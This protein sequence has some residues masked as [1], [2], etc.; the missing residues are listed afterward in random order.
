MDHASMVLGEPELR[1]ALSSIYASMVE[2]SEN[3][4]LFLRGDPSDVRDEDA[5]GN[6]F[7]R[8]A[9]IDSCQW[10]ADLQI[11]CHPD[12]FDAVLGCVRTA[13]RYLKH[14]RSTKSTTSLTGWAFRKSSIIENAYGKRAAVTAVMPE[15]ESCMTMRLDAGACGGVEKGTYEVGS[16]TPMMLTNRIHLTRNDIS[17]VERSPDLKGW[18][19]LKVA[20]NDAGTFEESVEMDRYCEIASVQSKR[21]LHLGAPITIAGTLDDVDD[22]KAT[23]RSLVGKDV[24]TII[25]SA[26][27][28]EYEKLQSARGRPCR[29]LVAQ[30]YQ[31]GD[32]QRGYKKQ[33][34]MLHFEEGGLQELRRDDLIGYVR[35]RGQVDVSVAEDAYGM[36]IP[37]VACLVKKEGIVGYVGRPRPRDP[38]INAFLDA[39]DEIR[40]TWTEYR[41]NDRLQVMET[42]IISEE[43]QNIAVIVARLDSRPGLKNA[44]SD[45]LAR[46]DYSGDWPDEPAASED[47]IA[48]K[49]ARS[50][51]RLGLTQTGSGKSSV[52]DKGRRVLEKA[53]K[54]EV[55]RYLAARDCIY[56]PELASPTPR[57]VILQHLKNGA[58]FREHITASSKNKLLWIRRETRPDSKIEECVKDLE[59]QR[60][61]ILEVVRKVNHQIN[62]KF[63][64]D[65]LKARGVGTDYT[66]IG[67][68]MRQLAAAG[69]LEGSE[70]DWSYPLHRR[71]PDIVGSDKDGEWDMAR[72][73]DESRIALT[74]GDLVRTEM[75][76]MEAKGLIAKI[77]DGKWAWKK[78]GVDQRR[79]YADR[80]VREKILALLRI[81]KRGMDSKILPGRVNA[82]VLD[83]FIDMDRNKLV[84]DAIQE[85]KKRNLIYEKE[86]MFH[87][88]DGAR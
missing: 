87:V 33:P 46:F 79:D 70:D 59:R 23:V 27:G 25:H 13:A 12:A 37:D 38:V 21:A 47:A 39:V 56:L 61:D 18:D 6:S 62:S 50:L 28:D 86:G 22:A 71:I 83:Q 31:P 57:S 82:M 65:E 34:E 15:L 24:I 45:T 66:S 75:E 7:V 80:V 20:F 4:E 54:A 81:K 9:M 78:Q 68:M 51:A 73:M 48:A 72:V 67:V 29:F 8:S 40:K 88:G 19:F 58:V 35:L 77:A 1:K 55:E 17:P 5:G 76:R 63:V 16:A 53:L 69:S 2:S 43:K 26:A 32:Y 44:L 60:N 49:Y 14:I 74:D 42:D 30:W 3:T 85:L 84:R 64:H 36:S 11:Q 41:R 52:T 10:L